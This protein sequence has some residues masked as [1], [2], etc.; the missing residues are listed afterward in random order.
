MSV[1]QHPKYRV[2]YIREPIPAELQQAAGKKVYKRSLGTTDRHAARERY[3]DAYGVFEAYLATLGAGPVALSALQVEALVGLWYRRQLDEWSHNPGTSENWEIVSLSLPT[4]SDPSDAADR[5]RIM[6]EHA[7]ALLDSEG[8]QVDARSRAYLCDRLLVRML[9]L[10]ERM[11]FRAEGDFSPDPVLQQFPAWT[12]PAPLTP[13]ARSIGEG[14]SVLTFADLFSRWDKAVARSPKTVAEYRRYLDAFRAFVGHDDP[15]KVDTLDVERWRD[16]LK[17]GGLKTATVQRK[18]LAS[19]SAL[20]EASKGSGRGRLSLNPVDGAWYQGKH[21]EDSDERRPYTKG[22]LAA[23]LQASRRESLP[24]LRWYPWLIAYSG[25]R[26]R[27]G[28]QL[29]KSD[30]RERDGIPYVD[31]NK[32]QPHKRVKGKP[33]RRS[34]SVRDVP[35]HRDVIAEGFLRFVEGLPDDAL[36]FP[37]IA[38]RENGKDYQGRPVD[39]MRQWFRKVS[40]VEGTA[41]GPVHSLRHSFEDQLREATEDTELRWD[42]QG[43]VD[44]SSARGYGDGHALRRK[45]EVIERIPSLLDKKR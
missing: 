22:E 8:L 12:P 9:Q 44:G 26:P 11:G 13:P 2:F 20:Y 24:E 34:P 41:V 31:V 3:R 32:D 25:L 27:E 42:I 5:A 40:G 28:A 36:L 16:S 6:G 15:A 21:F 17:A 7:D 43:R 45:R 4:G 10:F 18:Y 37:R 30:I 38:P 14:G 35:L 19:L 1:W 29:V 39:S 33:G 23:I